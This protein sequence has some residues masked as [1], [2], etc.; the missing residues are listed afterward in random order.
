M[1]LQNVSVQDLNDAEMEAV[2]GGWGYAVSGFGYTAGF[3][4][5]EHSASVAV[6]G[7]NHVYYARSIS[8]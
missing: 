2:T 8:Y 5:G 4:V 3:S 7:N 1:D 6:M